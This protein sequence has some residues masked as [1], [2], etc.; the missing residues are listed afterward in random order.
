MCIAGY[1]LHFSFNNI[2]MLKLEE[3]SHNE[4]MMEWYTGNSIMEITRK[5]CWESGG[6]KQRRTRDVF[7]TSQ[8]MTAAVAEWLARRAH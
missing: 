6:R 1:C 8:L 7:P 4:I 5:Q 3:K 2:I